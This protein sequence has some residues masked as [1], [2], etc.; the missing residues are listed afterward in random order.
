M[1]LRYN[2]DDIPIP[3]TNPRH[4]PTMRRAKTLTRPERG[5]APPPL[6]TPHSQISPF[7]VPEPSSSSTDAWV[8]FS[9]L[10]TFWAPSVLLSSLGGLK[11]K[12]VRQAWREKM[13]LCFLIFILCAVVG[14][15]TVGLQ[16]VLCP[17][18][19][20][21][22]EQFISLGTTSGTLGIQGSMFNISQSKSPDPS[23]NFYTLSSQLPGQDITTLF[24]RDATDFPHCLG[25]SFRAAQ[26]P[27]CNSATP[28]PLGPLNNS[29][30][31]SSAQLVNI[32]RPVG[33]D[34][35]QVS[36]LS[37]YIVLDG[38]VLNLNPYMKL[39]PNPIPGDAVD[40]ALRTLFTTPGTS[41]RDGTRLFVNRNDIRI[42]VPCLVER[43]KAGTIDKVTPGCFV[44]QLILYA[45][46]IVVMSLILVRFIMACVFN[47]FLSARLAGNPDDSSLNRSAI[48]PA[49]L[50][51]GANI[52]VDN[53]DGTAPWAG[54]DGAKKLAKPSKS[55]RSLQS[56]S[57]T[58]LTN[59]TARDYA[60]PV[61]S[62]AQI[63]AELFAVCLVTC[64]SEGE[65][66]LRT[67][68][69]SISSTT[70]SDQRKLLFVV[71]DG[72]ITGAGEKRSTPDICVG[73][74]DADQ[75]FGNPTPM[76]YVA[77]GSGSKQ[78]NRAMVYAGHYSA[79]FFYI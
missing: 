46:L 47:W 76:S 38:H 36:T 16:R 74:L 7:P 70:Y 53:K 63:G 78:E 15:A 52:S 62:L 77:V 33:Y 25:L 13:A 57:S 10:V 68:L 8:I 2:N 50:P 72:M 60:A 71:A 5:V 39:H 54:P 18:Q 14:F 43:Y 22:T 6:I 79:R 3:T 61:M 29:A 34:W 41:G 40:L 45:G 11:D 28:C 59:S 24:T 64:Y 37:N 21:E 42:A 12:A 23:I 51:G 48:S 20:L 4:G 73:L 55:L 1:A 17:Q 32:T 30:T 31:L 35:D 49:V 56:A 69:D 75:R 19:S 9:R 67:T 44:S 27:P 65:E 26:D 66:S 58:T